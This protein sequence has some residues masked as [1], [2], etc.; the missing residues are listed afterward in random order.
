MRMPRTCDT[1]STRYWFL[2]VN[3]SKKTSTRTWSPF[4]SAYGMPNMMRGASRCHSSSCAHT[5]P[6]AEEVA[7]HHVHRHQ[8]DDDEREPGGRAADEVDRAFD[9]FLHA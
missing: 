3:F 9:A 6:Y 4:S 7:Q 5:E 1:I 8:H 2:R